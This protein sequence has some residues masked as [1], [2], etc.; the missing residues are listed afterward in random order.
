MKL[1][2]VLY[3]L[4][5]I[6]SS[7][8]ST[9]RLSKL[10]DDKFVIKDSIIYI[11]RYDTIWE[12]IPNDTLIDVITRTDTINQYFERN[13]IKYINKYKDKIVYREN[14]GLVYQLKS[15]N[16][17]ISSKNK[18]LEMKLKFYKKMRNILIAIILFA[19]SF[20]IILK[21]ITKKWL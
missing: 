20:Q 15:Q 3:T 5:F 2:I 16:D 17:K 11:D 4:I 10:C 7:C 18:E 12:S 9:N 19:I 8:V 13:K 14:T 1:N 21:T 6:L